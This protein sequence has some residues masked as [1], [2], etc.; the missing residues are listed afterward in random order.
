LPSSGGVDIRKRRRDVGGLLRDLRDRFV[1]RGN[2][3]DEAVWERLEAGVADTDPVR[4]AELIRASIRAVPAGRTAGT[5]LDRALD[6]KLF[7]DDSIPVACF[8]GSGRLYVDLAVIRHLRSRGVDCRVGPVGDVRVSPLVILGS[9][10]INVL[11]RRAD[12]TGAGV[13]LRRRVGFRRAMEAMIEPHEARPIFDYRAA[14]QGL[15]QWLED[16]GVKL[17]RRSQL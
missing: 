13:Y 5:A 14:A 6:G 4:A 1:E 11:F 17:M 8:L 2:P 10:S 7:P 12:L 15:A 9:G 16:N 3:L